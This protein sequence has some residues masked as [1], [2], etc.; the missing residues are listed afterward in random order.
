LLRD[1]TV[2]Y[3]PHSQN[4]TGNFGIGVLASTSTA[5]L[6]YYGPYIVEY[7]DSP[8]TTSEITYKLQVANYLA[9]TTTSIN[10]GLAGYTACQ[11]SIVLMEIAQ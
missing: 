9:S 1:S 5:T 4:A 2:I 10:Y 3:T 7:V 11:A 8:A 6:N